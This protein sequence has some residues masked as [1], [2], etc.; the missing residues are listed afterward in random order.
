VHLQDFAEFCLKRNPHIVEVQHSGHCAIRLILAD[1]G[2]LTCADGL[3]ALRYRTA[4]YGE[5]WA[6]FAEEMPDRTYD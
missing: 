3:V 4:P 6:L 5:Q 1:G 2:E